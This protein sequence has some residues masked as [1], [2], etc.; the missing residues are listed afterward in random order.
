MPD[1]EG[2]VTISNDGQPTIRLNGGNGDVDIGESGQSGR[3]VL[4]QGGGD[5]AQSDATITLSGRDGKL[6]LREIG[7]N[8]A[9][10]L[11]GGVIELGTKPNAPGPQRGRLLIRDADGNTIMD[12]DAESGDVI[13]GGQGLRGRLFLRAADGDT[14]I[15][16]TG[17]NGDL[18]LGGGGVNGDLFLRKADGS[19]SIHVRGQTGDIILQNADCAEEFDYAGDDEVE[20]GDIVVL[21]DNGAVSRSRRPF[22]RRV[23]GIVSGAGNFRPAIVLDRRHNGDRRTPV[24]IAGKAFCKVDAAYAPVGVGDLLTTSATPGHAMLADDPL[25]AFGAVIGKALAPLNNGATLLPVLVGL[26]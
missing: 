15:Q 20:P 19:E 24:A 2:L 3:L 10:D 4:H 26:R 22:D 8:T 14:T 9:I 13:I 18:V 11:H 17:G 6:T 21:G 16:L 5:P 23:V 7:R 12:L 25:R 1:F